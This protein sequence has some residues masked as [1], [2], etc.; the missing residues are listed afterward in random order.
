MFKKR[1]VVIAFSVIS[2]F[3]SWTSVCW[4]QKTPYPAAKHGGNYMFN[5]Y[6][7]PAP[8]TTAWAP[9]WSPDGKWLAV[10][11]YG[12][13]WKVDPGAGIASEL[14]YNR[15]Y[16]SSPAFSP[17]GEWLVCTA[18]DNASSIQLEVLNLKSGQSHALTQD[19]H[20]YLDPVFSPDG[21]QL[22]YVST[23]PNGYFNVYVRPIRQGQWTGPE[24][25]LTEDHSFGRDRLYF[26]P[27]DMHTQPAWLP[28]GEELL[29]V[30]NR[31]VP[32][33]SGDIWRIPVSE[34]SLL[35]GRRIFSEQTLYRT[36]PD[37]SPD[38][39]RFVYSSTG[40][41]A[42]EYSHLYLLPVEGGAPYKLTFGEHDDFHPRWSPD[43]EQ[44]V[45]ISNH[46]KQAQTVGLPELWLLE[47]YGGRLSKIELRELR[48]KRPMGKVQVE[49]RD[50]TTRQLTAARIYGL[51]SDGK[52]YAPRDSF[53][54]IGELGEH[55]F[56]TDGRFT[57]EVP[58]G[59]IQLEAVK[60][61]EYWPAAQ[62]V[63]V[64][65][66]ETIQVTLTPRPMVDFAAK[67]WISGSTHV[68]MNYGGNLRNTLQNLI[69]MSKAEDQDV[70]N[71]LVANKDN[72]I[73]DWQH[74]VPGGGEHPT[75]K[76]D[77][78]TV[79]IV[80]EEYR[81]PFYGHVFFLGL[82]DHLINPFTTGY[83]G[84]AIESLYPSNTDMFRKAAAQGAA[85]GYV[86]A[87]S[88]ES[89]P[90]ET[91]LG[92]AKAFPVDAALGTIHA[93]EWS[94]A[95]RA[96]LR[97]WHHALNNDLP[98]A[99]VGGEDSITNLH[100]T[101][102]VGTVRTYAYVGKPDPTATDTQRNANLTAENWI[103]ALKRGRTVFSSG[104]LLEFQVN[105][106]LPG[107]A[108]NLPPSGGDVVLKGEVWSLVPLARVVIYRNG[109]QWKEISLTGDH[110]SA[111]FQER[112][113]LDQSSWLSLTAEAGPAS[114]PLDVVFPQA[115]TNAIRIY[116][117]DQKIRSRESAQYFI[118]WIEKLQSM[119][120]AWPGWRSQREKDHV[121]GQFREARQVYERFS[122]EAGENNTG[123][124]TAKERK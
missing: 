65:P 106:R 108:L 86:H 93:M 124:L 47:T 52:F 14:T 48:W 95:S 63:D 30:T 115:A 99:P 90:F 5:Y 49:V 92:L 56:H 18:D 7:P 84:T 2:V 33:G 76:Q 102:L 38:G 109:Q 28:N 25:A 119:A 43:G 51:A 21:S 98:I 96:A 100:R 82:R 101:K 6:I 53:S 113:R 71:E 36:R 112:V 123:S 94:T 24:V 37:V 116:V 1:I 41:A 70:V 85:V 79:L 80:G 26:G 117:G 22:A 78:T 60:G 61:F 15:K 83:E 50:G 23:R 72:R 89:D 35:K 114:H 104:P 77:P 20:L 121:F 13:I 59:T 39:K 97:V 68:H 17:D 12:S 9:A 40:G 73:L 34:K 87:F 55:L 120:E 74:F 107:E 64:L 88:G 58:P 19:S 42:D 110:R 4:A 27:W 11:A 45:F 46:S 44:I 3:S 118:R 81:P 29:L 69:F 57:L 8:S 32:L 66:D 62:S 67:G 54:R 105:D 111:R 75:S 122:K 91:G 31:D 103:Q 10:A 16:H